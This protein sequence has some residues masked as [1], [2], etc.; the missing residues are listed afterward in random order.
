M[1]LVDVGGE[2]T[3][4]PSGD[5]MSNRPE[6]Y[7]SPEEIESWLRQFD[8]FARI[9]REAIDIVIHTGFQQLVNGQWISSLA[10]PLAP[11]QRPATPPVLRCAEQN[12]VPHHADTLPAQR[13]DGA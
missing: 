8:R 7:N 6:V 1:I 11:R 10:S 5:P 3:G 13:P 2:S 4:S 9:S 12:P